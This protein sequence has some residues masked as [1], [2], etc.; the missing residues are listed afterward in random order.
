MQ[1]SFAK[2]APSAHWW[3]PLME[4]K[5]PA[6]VHLH[7]SRPML[8][9]LDNYD[10]FVYNLAQYFAELRCA[11][12]VKRNDKISSGEI[13]ALAQSHICISP[14][15]CTPREAGISKE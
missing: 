14:G 9:L 11:L 13:A 15:P 1:S 6:K 5:C 10:S 3:P 2:C 8:L 7:T 12:I 4:G